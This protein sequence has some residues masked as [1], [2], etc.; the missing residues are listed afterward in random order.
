ML[1]TIM[2]IFIKVI[3]IIVAGIFA[4]TL[5]DMFFGISLSNMIIISIIIVPMVLLLLFSSNI[6]NM[7][8]HNG[9]YFSSDIGCDSGGNNCD[10]GESC[11]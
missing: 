3:L 4:I 1:H 5:I 2:I 6:R 8:K 7:K 11:C 10:G 9:S